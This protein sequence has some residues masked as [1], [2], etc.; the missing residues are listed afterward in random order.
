MRGSQSSH[1]MCREKGR[2]NNTGVGLT[3]AAAPRPGKAWPAL[4]GCRASEHAQHAR[5]PAKE[6]AG[7]TKRMVQSGGGTNR[8]AGRRGTRARRPPAAASPTG[9]S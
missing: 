2:G 7:G 6:G 8:P 3:P 1:E 4:L 5:G 9:A